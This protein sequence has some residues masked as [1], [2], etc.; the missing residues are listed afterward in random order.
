M[1]E[2]SGDL[3]AVGT[4]SSATAT[5]AA[6]RTSAFS[7]PARRFDPELFR[8]RRERLL[9]RVDAGVAVL[10]GAKGTLD[11]WEERRFDPSFRI[12]GFRQE[13]NLFWLTGLE[14]PGAAVTV[15]L[16]DGDLQVFVP[17]PDEGIGREL[18]RLG[19]GA[20]APIANL[21]ERLEEQLA[22]R[23]VHLVTRSREVGSLRAGFGERSSFPAPLPGGLPGTFPDE[24]L[25]ARVERRYGAATIRSLVPTLIELRRSKDEA[26]LDAIRAAAEATVRGFAAALPTVAPGVEELEVAAAL[27]AGARRS[28]AQRDAFV[29]VVQSGTDGLL[30]FV[31]IVDAYDGLNRTL[32]TGELTMLDYGAELDYYVADLAR[33]VPVSG[34]FTDDQ[35]VAYEAY[36]EA[37]RA[38][39]GVVGPGR[40]FMD[41]A[42][43]TA[44][45]FRELLPDLPVWLRPAAERFATEGAE[46]RPGH[47]LGLEL[48]D[49]ER[50]REP[51]RPG[52]VVA[53]E[54]HFRIPERGWRITIEDMLLVT[55]RG[56]EMLTE[57][58]PR[59]PDALEALMAAGGSQ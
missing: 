11:A 54:H 19:L 6:E 8:R 33:T 21:D 17:D 29:P 3:P 58:L 26:E 51:L 53:Y 14:V 22:G 25:A 42:H 20:P 18:D 52:E 10:F 35:R 59:D 2:A 46:L 4:A 15:E 30:S 5:P 57:A 38:G 44:Q 36:L 13:P 12:L 55:D 34:R 49:H 32:E 50:Y 39:V 7:A 41:A 40:P 9:E 43:A 16:G 37:Y 47:F 1:S 56:C 48:H 24:E 28:G 31:D 45:A 27:Q 23:T